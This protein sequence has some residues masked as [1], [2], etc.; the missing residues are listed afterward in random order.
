MAEA[1]AEDVAA[2][3]GQARIRRH[4]SVGSLKSS[5]RT[6]AVPVAILV[7]LD[8]WRENPMCAVRGRSAWRIAR[9]RLDVPG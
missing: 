5:D 2:L 1:G 8:G 4:I 6:P 3:Q 7:S 9:P